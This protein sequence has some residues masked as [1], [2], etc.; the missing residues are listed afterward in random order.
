M[1][2]HSPGL[3]I[4]PVPEL[5]RHCQYCCT[6]VGTSWNLL[7]CVQPRSKLGSRGGSGHREEVGLVPRVLTLTSLFFLQ[8][9]NLMNNPQVQQL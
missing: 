3:G 9:S 8:A 5:Q 4:K 6:T 2:F 7:I 1:E